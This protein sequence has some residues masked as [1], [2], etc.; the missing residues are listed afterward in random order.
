MSGKSPFKLHK[1]G[2]DP[3]AA[4]VQVLFRVLH[5]QTDAQAA[6][7]AA[8]ASPYLAP[9]DRGLCTELVYGALRRYPG[10]GAFAE[11]FLARPEK[12][13]EEMKISLITAIYEMA[14]LRSP[15][16]ASVGWAVSHIRN[17]FGRVLSGV[18][19]AVLR[20]AQRELPA[21]RKR[22]D[23][24]DCL[25]TPPD[26]AEGAG[27]KG[28]ADVPA[29]ITQMWFDHYGSEAARALTRASCLA[30][31]VGLRLNRAAPAW[32]ELRSELL[33]AVAPE[34]LSPRETGNACAAENA[35]AGRE[36]GEKK[37]PAVLALGDCSLA[38]FASLPY[39]ARRALDQ[40]R[41]SRQS[42][43]SA[44]I[45][46][47][48][49]P[50]D[51]P[52]PL[53]D[54]C[55][56]RGGKTLALLEQGIRVDLASDISAR[57]LD[58]L[59]RDYARLGLSALPCP[60][61]LRLDVSD[62]DFG[63]GGAKDGEGTRLVSDSPDL[64]ERTDL[65][66]QF[67]TILLDAPCSGLGTLARRP[68][69][70]LRRSPADVEN[71]ARLQARMLEALWPRLKKGGCLIYMTCTVSPAENEGQT[72]DFLNRHP[73]AALGREFRTPFSSPLRE[74]FYGAQIVKS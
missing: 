61:L 46:N 53:W 1:A 30:P 49:S 26:A 32:E 24:Y 63:A 36:D 34:S 20:S 35:G 62:P 38:F 33:R 13:P 66:E 74:F 56:G 58:G 3:R 47:F 16:H 4:A 40:G 19:N 44:E 43:A 27:A 8:L 28:A 68:E 22:C 48:F 59:A 5:E 71:L 57:R 52:P 15:H 9:V 70:R 39:A 25:E 64:A 67:G 2:N 18:A 17:R 69:I 65:P 55:A 73:E 29:W 51:W 42:V 41:A 6:L 37:V 54:C 72:A 45:L 12:I 50:S 23:S 21:Y 14:F 60:R 7:D 10:L 31:P 11:S